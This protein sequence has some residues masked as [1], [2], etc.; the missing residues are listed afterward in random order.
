MRMWR[1]SPALLCNQHLLGAHSELHKFLPGFRQQH[2]VA[3]RI[4]PVVQIELTAYLQEHDA[5]AA[6]M[7]RRGMH[8]RSPLTQRDLPDFSYLP[9]GHFQARV[10]PQISIQDLSARCPECRQ[11]II[12]AQK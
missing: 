8:H 2:R 7:V 11:R 9:P 6:E 3:G 1:L 12:Q 4:F 10:D 5:L